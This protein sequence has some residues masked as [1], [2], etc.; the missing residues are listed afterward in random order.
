MIQ[1]TDIKTELFTQT[2]I[3]DFGVRFKIHDK[4]AF[5]K[6]GVTSQYQSWFTATINICEYGNVN[7]QCI[8]PVK[9]SN[10]QLDEIQR[11]SQMLRNQ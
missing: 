8:R 4:E 5:L 7:I 6:S 11:V 3:T 1:L 2:T 10:Q 9:I